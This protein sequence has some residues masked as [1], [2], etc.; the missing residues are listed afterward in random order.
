MTKI[1]IEKE[2]KFN[3]EA[4]IYT[5]RAPRP[6]SV[7]VSENIENGEYNTEANITRIK[8]QHN[9]NKSL[10][11]FSLFL[12]SA[13]LYFRHTFLQPSISGK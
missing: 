6:S 5:H 12:R 11:K 13:Q 7:N 1:Q 3:I 10:R 2:R 4:K 8:S 9:L